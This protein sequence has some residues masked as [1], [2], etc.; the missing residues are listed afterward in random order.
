MLCVADLELCNVP[1]FKSS[2]DLVLALKFELFDGLGENV[3]TV[4]VPSIHHEAHKGLYDQ[5][6]SRC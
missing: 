6:E 2:F 4:S 3:K 1:N 5:K